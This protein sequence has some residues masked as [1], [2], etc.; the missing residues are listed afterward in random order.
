[1]LNSR[2]EYNKFHNRYRIESTRL[3]NYD[4]SNDGAYFV[5]ICTKNRE[6]HLGEIVNGEMTETIQG[7]IIRESWLDLPNHYRNCILDEFIVMPNHVH[8]I[9]FIDNDSVE[10]GLKPVS[11]SEIMRGFK[12]FSARKINEYLNTQET[13]FWQSRFYD[14]IIRN[15][16]EL[17]RIREYI[18]D[19]PLKWELDENN[20]KNTGIKPN[21]KVETGFK[22]VSTGLK[23]ILKHLML[24]K[25]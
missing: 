17:A 22:P 2:N 20:L 10:T 21:N 15:E 5:T 9:I 16:N 3:Q 24:P 7:K 1:M 4:Y 12:T 13:P 6:C 25:H 18:I 14:H 8:G 19:N 23:T 11:L